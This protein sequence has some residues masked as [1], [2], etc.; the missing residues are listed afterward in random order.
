[1]SDCNEKRRRKVVF[2]NDRDLKMVQ[3]P[4]TTKKR[5]SSL[6]K[7]NILQDNVPKSTASRL[8]QSQGNPAFFS[9]RHSM[10]K[11]KKIHFTIQRRESKIN[12]EQGVARQQ[13]STYHAEMLKELKRDKDIL[14]SKKGFIVKDNKSLVSTFQIERVAVSSQNSDPIAAKSYPQRSKFFRDVNENKELEKTE[15]TERISF[16]NVSIM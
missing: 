8:Q 15:Q 9:N 1:M 4:Y 10:K 6:N 11:E 3:S 12:E 16:D 13:M 5:E 7:S 14:K 2:R